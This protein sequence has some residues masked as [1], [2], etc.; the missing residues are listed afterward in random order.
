MKTMEKKE[1]KAGSYVSIPQIRMIELV[2][3]FCIVYV[4]R[5][6]AG[7]DYRSGI[8]VLIFMGSA[9]LNLLAAGVEKRLSPVSAASGDKNRCWNWVTVFIDVATVLSLVY[10]TGTAQSPFMFLVVIPLFFAG[11]LLPA[12][13]SGIVVTAVTIGVIAT[14]G[15]LELKGLIPH[16]SCYAPGVDGTLNTHYLI[17][18][19]LVLTGFMSLLTYLFSTFY[20][21]FEIYFWRAENRLMNSRQRILELT[22]LYDISLGINSVISLDTLLKMVCKE[23]TLLLRRPWASVIL[24]SPN[25]GVIKFVELSSQGVMSRD[26]TEGMNSDPLLLEVHQLEEGIVIDDV[27]KN[28]ISSK[29]PLVNGK[30][31]KPLLVVPILSGRDTI[32]MLVVGDQANEIFTEEDVRLLTILSGQVATAIEKSRL[33]EVMSGRI[34]RLEHETEKLETA[35]KMKMGYISHL[36]HEFKTPLTSIKA[37]VESL[38]DNLDDPD[39]QEKND[40]LEVIST[41]TDRLIRM[42][43]KVLDISKIEFGQRSLRRKVFNLPRLIADVEYSL[44]PYLQEKGLHLIVTMPEEIPPVDG[45]EDLIKQVFINL[46]S[47]AIKFSPHGSRIFV[48]AAEDAVSIKVTIQDEGVGIPEED[49]K[50]IFKQ[51]YQAGNG[52]NEGVGLGLA[53]VKNIIEQHGGYIQVASDEGKGANF[54]FTL[55]KEHHFNDLL[56]YIFNSVDAREEIQEFFQLF[57]R[58]VAEMLSA[59]IVSLMLLDQGRKELFIKD[60]YGLDESVVER[61]RVKIG[62]G[63]AG[64]VVESGQPLL[65]EDIEKTDINNNKNNPQYETK[66]LLSIPLVVGSTVI[67][68]INVNNK[69]SGNPFTRDDLA[70]LI[71]LGQRFAKAVERMRSAEN[72]HSF[73]REAIMSLRS[74][75]NVCQNDKSGMKK[76]LMEWTVEVSRKLRLSEKEI[77]V[78]QY[79]SSVHDVGMTSISEEILR[80]TLELT[81]QEIEEI[82][83][84]PQRG[85]TIMRPLEFVELVSQNILFHHERVDGKGYPMGLKGD[86]IPVGS[87][88]LAVLDAYISMIS[89]RPFRRR[90]AVSESID[91]LVHNAG[92]Q[93][94]PEVVSAFVEVL[95]DEGI[96]EVE[97]YTSINDRLRFGGKHHAAH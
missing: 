2:V 56:G 40:F 92:A 79:V 22:R 28:E 61:T 66:S 39:F 75:L 55:P 77:Q 78:I 13:K 74:L 24:L 89:S 91:E 42:V 63:I 93:F 10:F 17:G 33:Y 59:K 69:T 95:M 80:K 53:I 21:N 73:L 90:L 27:E 20:D 71:S 35:N 26:P 70:L 32:G 34:S 97:E 41:E 67:G 86:Q 6:M 8:I 4:A 54:V 64:K 76:K 84:H 9:L 25:Q 62:E 30:G 68:V 49:L 47:N 83:K 37:Y 44:Q 94:D 14:L 36:S 5:E 50:N 57:V 82:R 81:S 16:Y 29:S 65:I 46:I 38:R 52:P 3:I 72:F 85:A 15:A 31:L 51:F 23:I 96:I 48:A 43:N 12:L 88:I 1:I 18:S 19:L 58:V 87:R 7:F 45:D 60:A 11:R